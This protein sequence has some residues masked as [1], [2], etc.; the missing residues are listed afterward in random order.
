MFTLGYFIYINI[1]IPLQLTKHHID[2]SSSIMALCQPE[3]KMSKSD[4]NSKNYILLSDS[5]GEIRKKISRAQTDN[6]KGITYGDSNRP[7]IN[8]LINIF[9]AISDSTPSDIA[10]ANASCSNAEFKEKVSSAII[11]CLQPISTSFNE[12]RQNRELL[13]DIA[14]KGAE[15]AVAEASSCMHK[16]KTLTGL[17][18]Y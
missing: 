9:A 3:K 17:S 11:R 7:G 4:I 8:N 6:I 15:E 13:R 2:S 5:T 14:K 16:L 1:I 18:V 12:W 10:Q